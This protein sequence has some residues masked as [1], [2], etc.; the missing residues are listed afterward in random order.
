M[1]NQRVSVSRACSNS[2]PTSCQEESRSQSSCTR[3]CHCCCSWSTHSSKGDSS[4]SQKPSRKGPRTR[5]RACRHW[6]TRAARCGS[7]GTVECPWACFQARCTTSRSSSRGACGSR[8][9]RS[10]GLSRWL[11]GEAEASRS[12]SRLRSRAR[13]LRN[14]VRASWGVLSGHR[15]AASLLRGCML[16]ST[17][18]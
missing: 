3:T 1:A 13:A 4:P 18:R 12:G 6:A 9:S 16:P 10:R 11:C 7:A 2:P 8:P 15:K 17:A 14:A 5:A